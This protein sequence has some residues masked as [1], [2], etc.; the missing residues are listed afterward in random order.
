MMMNLRER[1]VAAASGAP[2]K[3]VGALKGLDCRLIKVTEAAS[4]AD[5]VPKTGGERV[6]LLGS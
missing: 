6:V 2:S 3:T 4:Y 5:G 1:R